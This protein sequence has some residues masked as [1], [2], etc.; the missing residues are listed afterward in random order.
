MHDIEATLL[1]ELQGP[2]ARAR[3]ILLPGRG[4]TLLGHLDP[5]SVPAKCSQPII[6][7]P[8]T[9]PHVPDRPLELAVVPEDPRGG[10]RGAPRDGRVRVCGRAG[11]RTDGPR[12]RSGA[13]HEEAVV[14]LPFA[15]PIYLAGDLSMS[16]RRRHAQ[17]VVG[18]EVDGWYHTTRLSDGASGLIPA[19]YVQ[20]LEQ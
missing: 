15:A 20:L 11:E 9:H 6:P 10:L 16:T 17:V 4:L 19:S 7:V 18:A 5:P 12:R 8:S 14:A 1:S 3:Q 13:N 2:A